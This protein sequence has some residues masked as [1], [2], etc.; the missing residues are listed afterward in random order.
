MLYIILNTLIFPISLALLMRHLKTIHVILTSIPLGIVFVFITTYILLFDSGYL[1]DPP[2]YYL[3][4]SIY[5][6]VF[7]LSTSISKLIV[8][9][10][11]SS[12]DS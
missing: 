1:H 5:V 4:F 10:V 12:N 11:L 2:F 8:N 7:V 6:P 3:M 9:T